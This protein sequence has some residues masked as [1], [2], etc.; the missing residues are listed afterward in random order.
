M[1]K[2]QQF[3]VFKLSSN[4]I[5]KANYNIDL[6]IAQAQ[7]NAELISI[8]QNQVI[9]SIFK[10]KGKLFDKNYLEVLIDNIL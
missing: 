10:I 8:S 5:I 1:R 6:T 7:K 4:R 3:F 9:L 2:S